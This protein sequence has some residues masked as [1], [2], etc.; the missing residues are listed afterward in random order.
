MIETLADEARRVLAEADCLFDAE[1]VQEAYDRIAADIA[2]TYGDEPLH[3]VCVMTG[4]LVAC[5]EIIRRLKMPLT[6]DYLHATRYRGETSG[7]DLVWKVAPPGDLGGRHVL[8]IDDILDEGHTLLAIRNAILANQPA[9]LR[10][11]VLA[12]KQHQRRAP[13]VSAEFVG[14]SLPDRYVFGCGMDYKGWWRQLP[15]IHAVRGL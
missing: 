9:S 10:T 5:T 3:V 13:G 11:A 7:R 14:I 1:A 8:L 6:L 2:D 15:S 4:A 12:D